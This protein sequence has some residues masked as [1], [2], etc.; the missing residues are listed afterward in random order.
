MIPGLLLGHA[1][2]ALVV[3]VG[4]FLPR[5]NRVLLLRV[6]GALGVILAAALAVAADRDETWRT[7]ALDPPAAVLAGVTIAC[8]W[9]LVTALDRGQGRW[10]VAAL[11]GIGCTGVALTATNEWLVPGAL[12]SFAAALAV[13]GTAS[14]FEHRGEVWLQIFATG[15]M[16][17]GALVVD[18]QDTGSWGAPGEIDGWGFW[19]LAGGVVL[20]AGALPVFGVWRL[21]GDS[22][23]AAAPL[24]VGTGFIILSGP[25]SRTQPWVAVGLLAFS[26][27]AIGWALITKREGEVAGSWPVVVALAVAFAA[28]EAVYGAGIAAVL[29]TSAAATGLAHRYAGDPARSLAVGFSPL[30]LGFAVLAAGA[31]VAFERATGATTDEESIPWTT[32]SALF[33]VALAA[34]LTLASRLA[35]GAGAVR[36]RAGVT[37]LT[38]SALVVASLGFGLF[39]DDVGQLATDPLGPQRSV[40]VLH[41]VALA[42]AVAAG[43]WAFRRGYATQDLSRASYEPVGGSLA[44]RSLPG[45]LSGTLAA[46]LAF[47]IAGAVGWLTIEGLRVGFL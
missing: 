13:A 7:T 21:C 3:S 36:S 45:W 37:A 46:V 20:R 16:I 27:A 10:D 2:L 42:A 19:L 8:A 15:A 12:F 44:P 22:A 30:T 11:I 47:G 40:L 34:G 32:A 29:A 38:T 23:A 28:P 31:I 18:W 24:L 5:P 1:G 25:G 33:P 17:T 9:L 14:S 4:A 43:G 41:L 26:A 39:P 6:V 35:R